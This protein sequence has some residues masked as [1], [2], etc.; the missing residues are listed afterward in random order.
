MVTPMKRIATHKD[1]RPACNQ[2]KKARSWY[3]Q[4]SLRRQ[5]KVTRD[6]PTNRWLRA[7]SDVLPSKGA[8]LCAGLRYCRNRA[9]P[10]RPSF[11]T[12][13]GLPCALEQWPQRRC[14]GTKAKAAW[15]T[16]YYS[17]IALGSAT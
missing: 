16:H 17:V 10:T 9:A 5:H 11:V 8:R 4:Q 15:Y 13:T 7:D 2:P 1:A 14:G 12:R 3:P 6:Y